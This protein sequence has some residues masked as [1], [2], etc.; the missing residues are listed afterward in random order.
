M[1]QIKVDRDFAFY[2]LMARS[3]TLSLPQLNRSLYLDD[4]ENQALFSR[5]YLQPKF[6]PATNPSQYVPNIT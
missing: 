4:P 1:R 2:T 3:F 6:A 5:H